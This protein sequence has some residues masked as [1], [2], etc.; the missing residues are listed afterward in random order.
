MLG[1]LVS[2]GSTIVSGISDHFKGKQ[3]IKK[4]RIE[5][6]KKLIMAEAENAMAMAK[7]GQKQE[8]DLDRIATENMKKSWKDEAVMIIFYAPLVTVFVPSM[9]PYV[10]EGFVV[11]D[12]LPDWYMYLIVGI[13]VV[14]MGMRGMLT[15]FIQ[16]LGKRLKL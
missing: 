1:A 8:Y 9:A 16:M 6:E 15:K 3:E 5:A 4:T 11:L 13:T 14:T 2:L 12:T 10:K 7:E